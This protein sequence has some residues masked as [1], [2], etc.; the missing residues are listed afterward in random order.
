MAAKKATPTSTKPPYLFLFVNDY[1]AFGPFI[2]Q[3]ELDEAIT[4][5]LDNGGSLGNLQVIRGTLH[6]I[7]VTKTITI[8][9]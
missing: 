8:E 1:E 3:A 6:D 7:T 9:G 2:D 5:Q 4:E